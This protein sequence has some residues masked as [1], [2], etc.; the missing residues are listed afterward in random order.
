MDEHAEIYAA[1]SACGLIDAGEQPQLLALGGG[2]SSEIY[3]FDTAAGPACI[4]R[5]LP[6][7]RVKQ[8]W[9]APIERSGF[10]AAWFDAVGKILPD[11]VP[12]IIAQD[13]DAHLFVMQFLPPEQYPLWKAELLA[14]R[15]S[16][17]F[18]ANVG[19]CLV[20]IHSS[21]AGDSNYATSFDNDRIFDPLRIDPYLRA[22]ATAHPEC[23]PQ[24]HALADET[25][26]E[27]RA[28]VHGDVS[29]K[30]ILNGPNGPVFLDAE[31]ACYGDPAFDLAF[32][33]NHLLLKCVWRPS[34]RDG[35]LACFDA[36]L[37]RYREGIDWEP[38]A[39]LE[40]RASALLG[41]FL[42]ARIDGKS[43]VEYIVDADDKSRVRQFAMPLIQKPADKLDAIRDAWREWLGR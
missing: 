26:S 14:G 38:P 3:R 41:A 29:P 39:Q 8:D 1:L 4:K 21:T 33:L 5:A 28:L 19:S 22:T 16:P 12:T 17:S 10:E 32:C 18:A 11:A 27:K 7:L 6:K 2:V 31:T 15:T 23:A 9:Y 40:R 34:T 37:A 24:L 42:L 25:L 43:P 13:R 20:R 36:L 35:Y 30:N